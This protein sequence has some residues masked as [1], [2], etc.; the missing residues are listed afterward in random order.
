MDNQVVIQGPTTYIKDVLPTLCGGISYI[1]STWKP[2][3]TENRNMLDSYG[4]ELVESDVPAISGYGNVNMQSLSSLEGIKRCKSS[5][6]LK[7][8]SDIIVSSWTKLFETLN[9]NKDRLSFLCYHNHN[10][11][12]PVDYINYG[13][14]D[15]MFDFWNYQQT[16]ASDLFAERQLTNNFL[17]KHP[18]AVTDPTNEKCSF[19][20]FLKDA[21]KEGVEFRWLKC[22]ISL[23]S[24]L[25][26]PKYLT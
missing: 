26:D 7:I 10:G 4:V 5:R 13:P 21:C 8:R 9:C 19:R 6:V 15:L 3:S 22:N 1:W 14:T 18:L 24:Y 11:G 16:S 17:K 2:V 23:S 25:K 20:Y 12:Y